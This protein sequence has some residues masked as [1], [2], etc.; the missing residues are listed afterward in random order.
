MYNDLVAFLPH[1]Y[2]I[3]KGVTVTLKYSVISV[4]FGLIIGTI[5]AF[6]KVIDLKILRL[7]AHAYT[8]IFRGTPLLIQLTIIYFGLPGLIGLKLSVFSAGVI[9]FSLNSGAYVSEIIRAGIESVDKGQV[10]AAKALGI[11]PILRMKDIILPQ[12]FRSI[13][14][15]LVNELINLVKESCLISVIGEMDLMRRAQVV[16]AETYT[17]F[18]PMLTAAAAY[19]LMVLIISSF[20]LLLEKRLAI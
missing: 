6:L 5:L 19:Y 4:C 13:L 2:F 18:T 20:A 1:L 10:E 7:A 11:S 15:A 17:F 16:S 14:P 12:A 8:S 3:L 9:A